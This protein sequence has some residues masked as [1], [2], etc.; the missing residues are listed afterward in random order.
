MLLSKKSDQTDRIINYLSRKGKGEED[1]P[2]LS[3]KDQDKL[4]RILQLSALVRQH[5]VKRK[6][7]DLF[8]ATTGISESQA[9]LDY[10]EMELVMGSTESVSKQ[11]QRTMVIESA[12]EVYAKAIQDKDLRAANGALTVITRVGRLDQPDEHAIDYESFTPPPVRIGWYPEKVAKDLPPDR[13]LIPLLKKLA[14]KH[15]DIKLRIE[16]M[17]KD[18]EEID[19]EEID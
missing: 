3:Q 16:E 15:N 1:L 11:F 6:A 2:V 10:R 4:G 7:I 13:E 18:V 12:W 14:G 5:K 8:V 9:Y 17:T 19:H